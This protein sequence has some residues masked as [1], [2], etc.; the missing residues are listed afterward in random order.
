MHLTD[1]QNEVY[2]FIISNFLFGRSMDIK[3]NE[4]LLG[5]GVIDSTGVL[6]LVAFLE[7]QFG[8]RV[9]DDEVIPD[10]L[11]ST[12]R[13]AAYVEKKIGIPVEHNGSRPHAFE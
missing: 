7:E 8:I 4:S 6:E 5:K 13:I 9:E 11:D 2:S 12:A 10:N 3:E 1:I